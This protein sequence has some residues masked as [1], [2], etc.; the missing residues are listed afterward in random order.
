MLYTHFSGLTNIT[1]EDNT[2]SHFP[3][4]YDVF[5]GT[6]VQRPSEDDYEGEVIYTSSPQETD[7]VVKKFSS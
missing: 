6:E 7:Q 5:N 4:S 3:E 1:A 2:I